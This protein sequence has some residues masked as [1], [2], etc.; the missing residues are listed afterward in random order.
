MT[1]QRYQAILAV[2]GE[3]RTVTEVA[4]QRRVSRQT[5][6]GW[7]A[8]YEQPSSS[9]LDPDRT[10]DWRTTSSRTTVVPVSGPES[11]DGLLARPGSRARHGSWLAEST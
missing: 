9:E 4:A 3:G 8:R 6:H 7:L 11:A 5:V 2:I 10:V 1:E